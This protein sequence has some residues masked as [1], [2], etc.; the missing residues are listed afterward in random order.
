MLTPLV[1]ERRSQR[2]A[3][4]WP[5]EISPLQAMGIGCAATASHEAEADAACERR[6]AAPLS[7]SATRPDIIRGV[8]SGARSRRNG[9]AILLAPRA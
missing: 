9:P 4:Y 8:N 2:T 6:R 5:W 1:K 7:Q 3:K